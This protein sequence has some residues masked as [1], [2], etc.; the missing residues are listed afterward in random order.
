MRDLAGAVLPN[1]LLVS[2][3]AYRHKHLSIRVL[4]LSCREGNRSESILGWVADP[5]WFSPEGLQGCWGLPP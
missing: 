5:P 1:M 2:A 3:R 4:Q